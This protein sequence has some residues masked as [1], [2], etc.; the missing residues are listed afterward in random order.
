MTALTHRSAHGHSWAQDIPRV[1][2]GITG[3]IFL[4]VGIAGFAVTGFDNFASEHGEDLLGFHVNPMH[5]LVHVLLGGV[6]L[7]LAWIKLARLYGW[8]L[9]VAY[10]LTFIY[11]LFAINESWDFLALNVADNVLHGGTAL[12]GLVIALWPQHRHEGADRT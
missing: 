2:A 9:F 4:V 8:L 12:L 3:A 1:L 6:G 5:N 7:V 10:G 11:G